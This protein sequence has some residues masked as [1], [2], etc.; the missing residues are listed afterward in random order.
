MLP[1]AAG[2][3]YVTAG[4]GINPVLLLEAVTVKACDS[5]PPAATPLKLTVCRPAFTLI[6]TLLIAVIVGTSLTAFTVT[7]NVVVVVA[8]SALFAIPSM[9]ASR[10]DTVIVEVPL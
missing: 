1:V 4:L 2:D 5:P 10:T 9:P 6:E 7:V 8:S 3:V